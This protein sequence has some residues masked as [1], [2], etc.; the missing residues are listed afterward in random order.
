ME[1]A[2]NLLIRKARRFVQRSM[3]HQGYFTGWNADFEKEVV[4]GKD[5][6]EFLSRVREQF[7][8][9]FFF[10]PEERQK[11]LSLNAHQQESILQNADQILRHE[12]ALFTEAPVA[13]GAR[14]P[15]HTDYLSGYTWDSKVPFYRCL[16]APYPGGYDIK[17][18]WELSRFQF[19]VWLGMAYAF[20]G[21]EQY[22][23]EWV[24]LIEDWI[25][26]NPTGMGVNWAC[27]MDVAIRVVNWLWAY[28]FLADSPLLSP[29]FHFS[30]IRS[31]WEHGRFIERHLENTMRVPSNHYL[32]NL[33]GLGYLGTL[34]PLF[35]EALR[36][37]EW[38]WGE[39]Q[40]EFLR[41]VY[42]DGV[43]FEASTSYHRLVAEMVLSLTALMKHN[44][45]PAQHAFLQRLE[46]MLEALMYLCQPDGTFPLIGDHDNGRLHRLKVYNP[47][48]KEWSDGRYLL[49]VGAVLFQRSD[50][51]GAAGREWEDALWMLG[52]DAAS[53]MRTALQEGD[54]LNG[55]RVFPKGGWWVSHHPKGVLTIEW[56]DVGHA[57]RGAHAHNDSLSFTFS[58]SG[59]NWIVDG[60]TLSYT[61]D[62]HSYH[63]SRST[64]MH[65]LARVVGAEQNC[66]DE[67]IPFRI[68]QS[69]RITDFSW[70][71][72]EDLF[73]AQGYFLHWD[74]V[75]AL[76]RRWL[77]DGQSGILLI[78]DHVY[79]S[80]K[81][82]ELFLHLNWG[83]NEVTEAQGIFLCQ[84]GEHRL[85]IQPL[86][87]H[88]SWWVEMGKMAI[89][90]RIIRPSRIIRALFNNG[91][92]V[93]AI[94]EAQQ[95]QD[96]RARLQST[97]YRGRNIWERILL[98][99][100]CLS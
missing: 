77:F 44:R 55:M 56:G 75:H 11:R 27:T 91:W 46:K 3:D 51:A 13:L 94:G 93:Y 81:P 32:A 30:F 66:H 57:G 45:V 92:V 54:F 42:E 73:E 71:E 1:Q 58:S 83:V 31:L 9:R 48:E 79:P 10:T 20:S 36:W 53:F 86:S 80:S 82:G 33:V 6:E 87:A 15:W 97:L 4:R 26:C 69:G 90:Y 18:P 62:Y 85:M 40:R 99:T 47:P 24:R 67:R 28:A 7:W 23:L 25:S 34:M 60:G 38:S 59:V 22:A 35:P 41:Q 98:D 37:R 96:W 49:A 8:Q 14:I 17:V 76:E 39:F 64:A 29:S 12:I 16:P 74:Q 63:L 61:G 89:G 65:N 21:Q 88:S 2:I 70:R 72:E 84:S 43:S 68:I 5:R 95:E 19:G 50:F 100:G 78:A 52:N